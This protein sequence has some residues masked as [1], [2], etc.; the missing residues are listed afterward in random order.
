MTSSMEM[1]MTSLSDGDNDDMEI[2]MTSLSPSNPFTTCFQMLKTRLTFSTRIQMIKK[3]DA[4]NNVLIVAS[5]CK[6]DAYI[7]R[8]AT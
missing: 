5:C 6:F 8:A 7:L 2:M 4:N 3:Y 1:M